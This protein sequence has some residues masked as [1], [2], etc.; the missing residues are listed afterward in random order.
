MRQAYEELLVLTE[1][2]APPWPEQCKVTACS[3]PPSPPM[4][5]AS[6]SVSPRWKTV[7]GVGSGSSSTGVYQHR[8]L[9]CNETVQL[10]V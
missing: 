1:S 7:E 6:V 9:V 8:P 10:T 5:C 4:D 2:G 3:S